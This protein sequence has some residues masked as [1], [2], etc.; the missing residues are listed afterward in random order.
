MKILKLLLLAIAIILAAYMAI[1]RPVF[2][3]APIYISSLDGG[4]LD[5]YLDELGNHESPEGLSFG[6]SPKERH[7][8][9]K[10]G[11]IR[12][13]KIGCSEK[14][15]LSP[16]NNLTFHPFAP[17]EEA[18]DYQTKKGSLVFV[19]ESE[20]THF[21]IEK[22]GAYVSYNIYGIPMKSS[23]PSLIFAFNEKL[24]ECQWKDETSR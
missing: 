15:K 4:Y 14:I 12:S 23:N 9:I 22:N 1:L 24:K 7:D 2:K 13:E 11:V 19:W 6:F 16:I 20:S 8:G 5:L 10:T 18:I 21:W 3:G 17:S